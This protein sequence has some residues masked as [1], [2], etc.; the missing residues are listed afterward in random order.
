[1]TQKG[2]ST[3]R[4]D[5]TVKELLE[6]VREGHLECVALCE[7]AQRYRELATQ[8]T[9]ALSGMPGAHDNIGAQE[10]YIIPLMDAHRELQCRIDALLKDTKEAEKWISKLTDVKHRVVMQLYY[11]CGKSM[12]ELAREIAYDRTWCYRLRE[13]ALAQLEEKE[14]A[15]E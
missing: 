1:M 7:R 15:G 9:Q 8:C 4:S 14:K 10:R 2:R 5:S 12:D 3:G 6:N 11:L 13:E